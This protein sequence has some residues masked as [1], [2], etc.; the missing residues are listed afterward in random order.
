VSLAEADVEGRPHLIVADED[1]E[2]VAE[3]LADALLAG[4]ER[5]GGAREP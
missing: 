5:E 2:A 1:R 4:L 3:L